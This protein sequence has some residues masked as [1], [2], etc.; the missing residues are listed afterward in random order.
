MIL[1]TGGM[2]Y[3]GSHT[4]VE[5]IN[6]GF[7]P[8]ILDNLCNSHK[9]VLERI[10]TITGQKPTFIEGD[11]RDS[12]LLNKVFSNYPIDA[13]IH[14]AGLK[15][16]GESV[17]HPLRYYDNNVV[18]S[19]SLVQA[20]EKAGVKR[21][22]FSSS[23]T[24]YG[25]SSTEPITESFSTKAV[26]PYGQSKL[27]LE[28]MFTDICHADPEWQMV[29]LRYFN[30]IGAHE[31]GLIGEDP[32]GI[33]NN[34]LPFISQVAIGKRDKLQVFGGDYDTHDG[35]GVRDY[36]HVCDLAS[37]HV[38]ALNHL[39]YK[40][41]C[42]AVNLGTGKGYSVLDVI[43]AFEKASNKKIP[44]DV[45]ERR[46]GDIDIYFADASLANSLLNWQAQFNIDDMCRDTWRW[47]QKNPNGYLG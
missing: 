25:C 14:F 30:P 43:N 38:A 44:Y 26:N 4:C 33:P 22:I 45:V 19:L 1:V 2:G 31:S 12:E 5:L 11:I 21:L 20:M 9:N 34:L 46:L 13:V 47:Q 18:G 24:V 3:I 42:L 36:I 15:A 29:I 40:S 6:A 39:P 23:A 35:T 8:I 17:Q 41:N 7:T 27:I 28:T 10:E 37:G 32:N 16:V